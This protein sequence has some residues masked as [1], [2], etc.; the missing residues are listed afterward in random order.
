MKSRLTRFRNLLDE[1]ERAYYDMC[2]VG[3]IK[4]N[5]ESQMPLPEF[6]Q[7]KLVTK[8]DSLNAYTE[9]RCRIEMFFLEKE[10]KR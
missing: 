6:L 8:S 3:P 10:T 4:S 1:L 7:T 2:I 5:K 9:A